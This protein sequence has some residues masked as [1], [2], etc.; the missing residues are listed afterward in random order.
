MKILTIIVSYNFEKWMNRCLSS[1][2]Q[3]DYPTDVLII[4]NHSQD[5]TLE[6]L[7]KSYPFARVIA[8]KT[9]Q[10]FGKANNIGMKLALKEKYD[11][12]FLLNQDA[13]IGTNVLRECVNICTQSTQWGI[14]SPVHLNG[15]GTKLDHGFAAYT[16]I[17]DISQLPHHSSCIE[18]HFI[19]AA[20]WFIPISVLQTIGG[21]S[22]LFQHYGEDKD[23]VN[24]LF[25][26]HY[27]I[28]YIPTVFGFHDRGHRPGSRELF[29][30]TEHVYLLSE[31]AN[32]NYPYIHAF[33]YSVLAGLKKAIRSALK[34][35]IREMWQYIK[36]SGSLLKQSI[37]VYS[38]RKQTIKDYP[39]FL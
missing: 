5:D 39:N 36:I 30:R 7:K 22:P 38:I 12:V 18:A 37:T 34:G 23:F 16:G 6:H 27:H 3:S 9:N 26:H 15:K 11:A 2:Q 19:N 29:F 35:K 4:D 17:K 32:I 10:G 28:G 31:Y 24:R 8:N 13:W 33:A 21:F 25:F 14:I 20:F 1:L